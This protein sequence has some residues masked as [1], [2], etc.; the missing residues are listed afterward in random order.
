MI[1]GAHPKAG[2][3]YPLGKRIGWAEKLRLGG[4]RT[5]SFVKN[6]AIIAKKKSN[7]GPSPEYASD[8]KKSSEQADLGFEIKTS[9]RVGYAPFWDI[10]PAG[11]WE[12]D[13]IEI[14]EVG[15]ISSEKVD[16][17]ANVH[18]DRRMYH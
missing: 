14:R 10:W 2:Y 8:K 16:N 18:P 6:S 1:I 4:S 17:I 5:P 3:Y 7:F 11:L 12:I 9:F 15:S 13:E